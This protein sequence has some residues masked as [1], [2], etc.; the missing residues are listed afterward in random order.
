MNTLVDHTAAA[1]SFQLAA[2]GLF[3]IVSLAAEP[4]HKA[5]AADD[6]AIFAAIDNLFQFNGGAIQTILQADADLDLRMQTS[7]STNSLACAVFKPTGFSQKT[8]T[9]WEA[10]YSD[11][12]TCR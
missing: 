3:V 8:F 12:G 9:P 4:G 7:N 5:A 1:S 10:K 6:L 2:P 11:T